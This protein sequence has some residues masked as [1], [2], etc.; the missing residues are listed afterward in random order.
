[1]KISA[2]EEYGIRCLLHIAKHSAT[3]GCSISAISQAEHISPSNTAK[4]VR[5]LRMN[6]FV[7]SS[8]GKSGGYTLARTPESILLS[9]VFDVL[10]GKL[11]DTGFCD[12]YAGSGAVC[13]H[14]SHCTVRS[15]WCAIQSVLDHVLSQTSLQHLMDPDGL[16]WWETCLNANPLITNSDRSRKKSNSR[17]R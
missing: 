2:Q 7:A 6:G 16:G 11:F 12:H 4:L 8:R 5:I 17:K 9:E 10:G 3:G 14:F 1:M 13:T 15:F